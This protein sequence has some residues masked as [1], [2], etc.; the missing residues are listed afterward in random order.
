MPNDLL[1]LSGNDIPFVEAQVTIHQPTL[2]EIAYIGEECF[3][4]G[5]QMLKVNKNNI[6]TE[7]K[8]NLDD[9]TNFDILIAILRERNAV[10]QKNRNCVFMV[11]SL[12]FPSYAITINKEGIVLKKENNEEKYI[13]DK[14]NFN[15]FQKI[16]F[17]MFAFDEKEDSTEEFNPDGDMAARIADK[18]RKRHE[19]L[20]KIKTDSVKKIDIISR[21]A[22]TLAIGLQ[23]NLTD[24]MNYTV[25][26]LFDQEKRL[27][28]KTQYDITIQARLAGAKDVEDPQDWMAD[29][30]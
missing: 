11:L 3:F 21:Y 8:N 1:L 6:R 5:Y 30:H 13:I 29:I 4:T 27:Q 23:L 19:K 12:L 14:V 28:L 16:L 26:Q 18:I 17:K 22:S 9:L 24:I 20:A 15:I 10:M 25:Y 2:K 7:G